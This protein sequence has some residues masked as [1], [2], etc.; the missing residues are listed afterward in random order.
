MGLVSGIILRTVLVLALSV[1]FWAVGWEFFRSLV[2]AAVPLGEPVKGLLSG[3]LT[4][5][6]LG[7]LNGFVS[8]RLARDLVILL[9]GSAAGWG[10]Y[11]SLL[12][13]LSQAGIE[14][15]GMLL[16]FAV[17]I[18]LTGGIGVAYGLRLTLVRTMALKG[19]APR[20]PAG[21]QPTS[22]PRAEAPP[23]PPAG[24]PVTTGTAQPTEQRP[25]TGATSAPEAALGRQEASREVPEHVTPATEV[26]G[27]EGEEAGPAVT[28]TERRLE[29]AGVELPAKVAPALSLDELEEML[30]DM[31]VDEGLS[32]IVPLPNNTSPEGGSFPSIESRFEVDTAMVM[33]VL[34]RLQD[35]NIIRVAG[36]EFK[37]IVCPHCQSALH[38]LNLRCKSCSSVNIGRQ[39]VMQHESCGYLGP[40]TSFIAGER[41]ICPRCGSQVLITASPL[42]EG[43][44]SSLKVHSTFFTCF[45]CN[46]VSLDPYITF[47]C[48]ICGIDYDISSFEFK[49]FY[50]YSVNL[51]ITSALQEKNKP[52]RLVAEELKRNGFE[53]RVGVR[54]LG[55]SKVRHRVDLLFG[56]GGLLNRGVFVLQDVGGGTP[57]NSIIRIIFVKSDLR[58]EKVALL[59]SRKLSEDA[60]VLASQYGILLIEDLA[61]KNILTEVVPRLLEL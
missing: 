48:L 21:V 30:V 34:R 25:L 8:W 42:E 49:T 46:E 52:L 14:M 10:V 53:A 51:E 37:K 16:S 11:F 32:E 5:L 55:A 40:E 3:A 35:K 19:G 9:V 33:R 13:S 50:K 26:I 7:A 24:A 38:T 1:V 57:V 20:I 12:T 17:F 60:R 39:R 23:A 27:P 44:A 59:S 6:L 18:A 4:G 43:E 45:D 15:L 31:I 56:R 61:S 22:P 29:E 36:V 41:T 2:T 58:L 47:R 28:E 54:V